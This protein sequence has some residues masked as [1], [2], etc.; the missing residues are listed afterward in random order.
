M[1]G[2]ARHRRRMSKQTR[3]PFDS[4]RA[5]LSP[6]RPSA[7]A[8]QLLLVASDRHLGGVDSRSVGQAAT[9]AAAH[10]TTLAAGSPRLFGRPLVGRSFGMRRPAALAGDLT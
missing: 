2:D 4:E 8:V 7:A 10:L 9:A 5:S 3:P 6:E 1:I